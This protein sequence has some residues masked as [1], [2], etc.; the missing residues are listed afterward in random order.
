[1]T[2]L[3]TTGQKA[4][5]LL[6]DY[7]GPRPE[8]FLGDPVAPRRVEERASRSAWRGGHSHLG[9][10]GSDL[11]GGWGHR[12]RE[13]ALVGISFSFLRIS[14]LQDVFYADTLVME[15]FSETPID[16]DL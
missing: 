9:G 3:L 11:C 5:L 6:S 15:P 1:M 12:D 7:K 8:V 14:F 2:P 16:A 13:A 4:F 10:L